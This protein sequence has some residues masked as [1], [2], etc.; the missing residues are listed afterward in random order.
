MP[1]WSCNHQ[2]CGSR[3]SCEGA[4]GAG[5][6]ACTYAAFRHVTGRPPPA[7]QPC[8]GLP[9]FWGPASSLEFSTAERVSDDGSGSPAGRRAMGDC[10]VATVSSAARN[11]VALEC[12]MRRGTAS[13][14][15]AA[16]LREPSGAAELTPH[17]FLP[18]PLQPY[19]AAT[20]GSLVLTMVLGAWCK[21]R[22]RQRTPRQGSAAP[23]ACSGMQRNTSNRISKQ[24]GRTLGTHEA[25]VQSEQPTSREGQFSGRVGKT[26]QRGC[27][28]GTASAGVAALHV[29]G[30]L[31]V[32]RCG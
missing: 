30:N 29:S 3:I 26:V 9:T 8:R 19:P 11:A 13:E 7:L 14:P 28:L 20:V 18:E 12:R 15:G 6:A 16:R 10:T 17:E 32:H 1:C 4:P 23:P 21:L 27:K 31:R 2:G 25:P 22:E 24:H 5:R